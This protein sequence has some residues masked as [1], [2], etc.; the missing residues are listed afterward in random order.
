MQTVDRAT[1]SALVRAITEIQSD[2][3]PFLW[4]VLTF[5]FAVT[6]RNTV[7]I[8]STRLP[9]ALIPTAFA[10][11]YL[12]YI[13]IALVIIAVAHFVTRDSPLRTARVVLPCFLFLLIAPLVDLLLTKGGGA[14]INYITPADSVPLITRLVTFFGPPMRNG[15]TSGMRVEIAVVLC[16][17]FWIFHHKLCGVWRSLLGTLLLYM[18]IFVFLS[19]P[20]FVEGG[21]RCLSTAYRY[22][23]EDL[24]YFYVL[25]SLALLA[26]LFWRQTP[27]LLAVLA[28]NVRVFRLLHY[29]LMFLF[30]FVITGLKCSSTVAADKLLEAMVLSAAVAFAWM[31]AVLTNDLIDED[32]DKVSSPSRPLAKGAI[33]RRQIVTLSALCFVVACLCAFVVHAVPLFL[34]LCFM[35][36]YFV[37]SVPPLRLKRIPLLSKA[38]ISANSLLLVLLGFMLGGGGPYALPEQLIMFFLGP[39]TLAANFIDLKDYEGDK[40]CGIRTLPVL[41]GMRAAQYLVSAFWLAAYVAFALICPVAWLRLVLVL[42]GILQVFLLVR[43]RYSETPVFCVYLS[44][45][46]VTLIVLYVRT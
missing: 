3:T 43:R 46:V 6:I 7:E 37:Y 39:V 33:T 24:N 34:I 38:V 13:A 5:F 26:V 15:V 44:S 27:A 8:S 42:V 31:F 21:L 36:N 41:V 9:L 40:L 12:A 16:F 35:A 1:S 11:Y 20:C 10:H 45:L 14:A 18:A 2:R 4:Y 29:E 23:P 28:R 30:G 32:I 19:V 22:R 17:A 25:G